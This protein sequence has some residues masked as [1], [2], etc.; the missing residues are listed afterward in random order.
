MEIAQTGKKM[1]LKSM[2]IAKI[3]QIENRGMHIYTNS[4][5]Q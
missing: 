5:R 2:I 4:N 3:W 1:E